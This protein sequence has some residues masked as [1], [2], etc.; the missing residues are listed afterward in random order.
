MKTL[1]LDWEDMQ[2]RVTFMMQSYM[3]PLET[4][5]RDLQQLTQ[6]LDSIS[7]KQN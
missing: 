4:K 6:F 1:D 7:E 5:I 3:Q 2:T